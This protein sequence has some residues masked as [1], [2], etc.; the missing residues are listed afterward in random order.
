MAPEKPTN[1]QKEIIRQT[2][3]VVDQ[4]LANKFATKGQFESMINELAAKAK[5]E[6]PALSKKIEFVRDDIMA[7][8]ESLNSLEFAEKRQVKLR[9]KEK[10][11]RILDPARAE[12]TESTG[13]IRNEIL[14]SR[15]FDLEKTI[16][17]MKWAFIHRAKFPSPRAEEL[18]SLCNKKFQSISNL[19]PESALFHEEINLQMDQLENLLDGR[20]PKSGQKT[21]SGFEFVKYVKQSSA[22][23]EK[24]LAERDKQLNPLAIQIVDALDS[25]DSNLFQK[26]LQSLI[27]KFKKHQALN[28]VSYDSKIWNQYPAHKGMMLMVD[29]SGQKVELSLLNLPNV[30]IVSFQSNE[31]PLPFEKL[32]LTMHP[33]SAPKTP[34]KLASK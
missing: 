3:A 14:S 26:N 22:E 34:E 27:S 4:A 2:E 24:A 31:N 33:K 16:N 12:K 17:S 18:F 1:S 6:S 20:D 19:M 9:T 7:Q 5:L 11:L 32:Y 15:Y 29:Q 8:F 30:E 25:H 28:E 10:I 13:K 23:L 21:S